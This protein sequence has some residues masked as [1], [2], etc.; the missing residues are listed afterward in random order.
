MEIGSLAGSKL[1]LILDEFID[2]FVFSAMFLI[3][4]IVSKEDP[5]YFLT[6]NSII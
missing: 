6:I 1:D 4:D 3:L 2:F 5:P